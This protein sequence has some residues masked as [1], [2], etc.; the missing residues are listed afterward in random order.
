MLKNKT[1]M[2]KK[3]NLNVKYNCARVKEKR[4]IFIS[5]S[6]WFF[7]IS[8]YKHV[9]AKRD[10]FPFY[11]LNQSDI[12]RA[13]I[14]LIGELGLF[15]AYLEFIY[16]VFCIVSFYYFL[17]FFLC[18]MEFCFSLHAIFTYLFLRFRIL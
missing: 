6:F 16:N 4:C 5:Y 17:F 3:N 11:I 9:L 2:E 15:M 10:D 14:Y 12:H 7:F 1:Q 18:K 8:G 13:I